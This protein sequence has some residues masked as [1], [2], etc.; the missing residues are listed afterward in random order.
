M[1][2]FG[3]RSRLRRRER[4][5]LAFFFV[6][7]Q[8]LD[9]HDPLAALSNLKQFSPIVLYGKSF[10][11]SILI[12]SSLCFLNTF[13]RNI[14]QNEYKMYCPDT[15]KRFSLEAGADPGF[16]LGGGA[17]VSCST[18]TPINHIVFFAE[19]QLY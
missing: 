1:H 9:L 8:F 11:L 2:R 14:C 5:N 18:S 13:S 16:F 19:Y 3:V 15:L 10:L 6:Q 4:G 7:T 17:L 12:Y